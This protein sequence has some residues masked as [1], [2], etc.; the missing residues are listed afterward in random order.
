MSAEAYFAEAQKIYD[1]IRS[2]QGGNIRKAAEFCAD[3][4][5]HGGLVHLFGSGHSVIPVMDVFPRYGSFAGFH[6][7]MDARLMWT[8]VLGSGGVRELLKLE[9]TEGYVATFLSNFKFEAIDTMVVYSHGGL[10]AAGIDVALH[11]KALGLK[12]VAVTS[13]ENARIAKTTHSSGKKLADLGDVVIDN[14]CPP[15]DSLVDVAG[16]PVGA[17]STL[18]V[19]AISMALT[20]EIAAELAQRGVKFR[21]FVSP[22]VTTVG[23]DNNRQVFDDYIA[24]VAPRMR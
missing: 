4:I 24:R 7:L 10:N 3:S 2:T 5:S 6:P 16:I 21:A 20:A 19:I 9:R 23:P 12:V 14:C 13:L 18:A 15:R 1:R 22:N 8:Q 17:S 11:A